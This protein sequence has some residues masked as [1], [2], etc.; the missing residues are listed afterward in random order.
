[1]LTQITTEKSKN[2]AK[3]IPPKTGHDLMCSRRLEFLFHNWHIPKYSCLNRLMSQISN[4]A[5]VIIIEKKT[6]V[7]VVYLGRM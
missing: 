5:Y 4:K 7:H 3:I 1:M 2:W 6:L